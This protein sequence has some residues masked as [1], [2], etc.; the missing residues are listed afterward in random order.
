M[1]RQKDFP[2]VILIA[3]AVSAIFGINNICHLAP[4]G[5]WWASNVLARLHLLKLER[6]SP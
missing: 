5:W 2:R 4:L 6:G 1:K 3:I